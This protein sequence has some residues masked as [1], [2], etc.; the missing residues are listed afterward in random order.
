MIRAMQAKRIVPYGV[1]NWAT[2]VNECHFVDNT[3]PIRVLEPVRTP[4]FLRPKRFGKSLVCSML[5]HYYDV[6]LADRF[7]ELFGATDIGRDPTPLHN[8]F[9]VLQFD[10][11]TIQIGTVAEIERNFHANVNRISSLLVH[12][13]SA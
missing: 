4:V 1:I 7:D 11:S 8:S 5:A 10:F 12:I 3:A 9:L 2:L 13:F 6:A